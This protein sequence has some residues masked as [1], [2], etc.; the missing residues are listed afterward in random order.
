MVTSEHAG[1]DRQEN[2]E[3]VLTG[4][5]PGNP[6]QH[7]P[8]IEIYGT[9]FCG[10]CTAARMLLKKKGLNYEDVPVSGDEARA[11][12]MRRCNGSSVPQI[13]IA[14]QPIGGFDELYE[15]EESG[16]LDQLLGVQKD[17]GNIQD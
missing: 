10:Y 17:V 2:Q 6:M 12:M 16:E 4:D 11:E 7:Q 5:N 13:L 8:K 1:C 3:K 14:D 9:Q 15:L